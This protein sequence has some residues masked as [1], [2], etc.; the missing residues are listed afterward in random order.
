MIRL[1]TLGRVEVR[2]DEEAA[3]PIALQPKQLALLAHLAA[4][5]PE[6]HRRDSL[7]A[8]LWPELGRDR[9]RAAL[10]QALYGVRR[11]VGRDAVV[12][13]GKASVRLSADHVWCDVP[14]FEEHLDRED[15]EA[16]LRLYRGPFLDGFHVR[17]APPYERWLDGRRATLRTKAVETARELAQT[18][19]DAGDPSLR[20]RWLRRLRALAPGDEETARELMR[21]LARSGD[22]AGAL[23]AYRELTAHLDR[24]LGFE[25]S[26]ETR[27]LA[28]EIEQEAASRR[29]V[30]VLPFR[31]LGPGSAGRRFGAGLAEEV[32]NALAR[33]RS[34]RVVGGTSAAR[35]ADRL[36]GA[37]QV[38]EALD[39]DAVVE[40]SV[41]RGDGRLRVTARLVSGEDGAALWSDRYELPLVPEKIFEAQ[42]EIARRIAGALEGEVA[43]EDEGLVRRPTTDPEAYALYLDGRHAWRR[44]TADALREALRLF[45]ASLERDPGNALAW[46][47]IADSHALLRVYGTADRE[48]SSRESREAAARALE[49]APSLAEART[50]LA[51]VYVDRRRWDE[52]EEE[53]RRA[54]SSR[55][56]YAPARHWLADHLMRTGRREEALEEAERLV[57]LEPLSPF[58]LAGRGFLLYLARDHDAA[59]DAARRSRSLS[60][61]VQANGLHAL[62]LAARGDS[63]EA[64]RVAEEAAR[65][66][67]ESMLVLGVVGYVRREAGETERARELADELAR[68]P[69]GCFHA[70]MIRAVDGAADQAFRLLEEADWT[71]P[72][73]DVFVSGPPFDGLRGD[74]RYRDRLVKLGLGREHAGDR[75]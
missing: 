23:G 35:A 28:R 67:P 42:E 21:V 15:R 70:A 20:E 25:P 59:V 71:S 12:S 6:V 9:A 32:L 26:A 41:R 62:A 39:V 13:D 66:W 45:G 73:A 65:R 30:A 50:S 34:L 72:E 40:G 31:D 46:S 16:A 63:A 68:T 18:A 27:R 4:A 10:N 47:G 11:A 19:A 54:L 61:T 52:A 56:S 49:L 74:P 38:A 29:S 24:S 51:R 2:P 55:P 48:G 7:L 69:G 1:R 22:R 5:G 64:V 53:L 75:G 58:A 44:R 37:V 36:A 8:L 43:A 60:E 57:E 17:G 14:A 33:L 3:D